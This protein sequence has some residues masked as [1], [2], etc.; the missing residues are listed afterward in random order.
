[1]ENEAVSIDSFAS[2][3][4]AAE[5][6]EQPIEESGQPEQGAAEEGS[7]EEALETPEGEEGEA[8]QPE[9]ESAGAERVHKW[10][11][12]NGEKFEV[13]EKELRDGYLRQQDYTQ[14]TQKVEQTIRAEQGKTQA[15]LQVME[16]LAVD[17]GNFQSIQQRL[18][19]FQQV[20][21]NR[22]QVED[23]NQANALRTEQLLLIEQGRGAQMALKEKHQH[24]TATQAE[25]LHQRQKAAADYLRAKVPKVD[26]AALSVACMKAGH[27]R[28]SL[29]GIADPVLVHD[30]WK[31]RQWDA[32]QAKKPEVQNRVR[33]LPPA[34]A[35]KPTRVTAP[36]SKSEAVSR[37]IKSNAPMTT[38]QYASLLGSL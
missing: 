5:A 23:P 21:W 17:I 35:G 32:L 38:R 25:Q 4:A 16:A 11:T 8:E 36:P 13:P 20:D 6:P 27:S 30:L 7:P 10:E 26:I 34:S 37:A 3:L 28:D 29:E 19:Q 14:K 15:Q 2:E 1:M 22:L 18:A 24:L 9:E 12:A 33:A 31:A